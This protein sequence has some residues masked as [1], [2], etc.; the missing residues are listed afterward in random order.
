VVVDPTGDVII[1]GYRYVAGQGDNYLVAKYPPTGPGVAEEH[2]YPAP[3]LT[4][5]QVRPTVVR[6]GCAFE[7][8]ADGSC[9]R[10]RVLDLAGRAVRVLAAPTGSSTITWD[11]TDETGSRLPDGVYFALAEGPGFRSSCKFLLHP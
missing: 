4:R 9:A 6:R 3:E 2:P 5:L 11:A 7:L 1:A 8:P 10:V